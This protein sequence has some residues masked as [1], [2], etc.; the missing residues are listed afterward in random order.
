[1]KLRK[2]GENFSVQELLNNSDSTDEDL[3]RA[4]DYWKNRES[5]RIPT[6]RIEQGTLGM[7]SCAPEKMG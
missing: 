3:T 2:K 5:L 4:E 7:Y 6:A 1:M